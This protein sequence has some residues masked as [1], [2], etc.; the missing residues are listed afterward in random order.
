LVRDGYFGG[1]LSSL[2][3]VVNGYTLAFTA[4]LLTVGAMGDRYDP[5][6]IFTLGF[7]LFAVA[8]LACGATPSLATLVAARIVQGVGGAMIVPSSRLTYPA[9]C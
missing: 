6:Q 1:S 7:A 9:S 2:E 8:S 5:K 4:F 3:W